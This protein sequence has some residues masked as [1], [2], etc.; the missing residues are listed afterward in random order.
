MNHSQ[1][2]KDLS[3]DQ[4]LTIKDKLKLKN[5]ILEIQTRFTMAELANTLNMDRRTLSRFI[6][7]LI[8]E[9]YVQRLTGWDY[10]V[11]EPN[12]DWKIN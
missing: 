2:V 4:H 8:E 1:A 5:C 6:N 3:K 12:V 10:K 9:G 11:T 7:T